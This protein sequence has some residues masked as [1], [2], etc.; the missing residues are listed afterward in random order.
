MAHDTHESIAQIRAEMKAR[1]AAK[2]AAANAKRAETRR[3]SKLSVEEK[4]AYAFE[5]EFL[6][7]RHIA[8]ES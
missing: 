6:S 3:L 8:G 4:I 5:R 1:A 2:K 7:R